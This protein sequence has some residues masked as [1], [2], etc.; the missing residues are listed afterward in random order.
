MRPLNVAVYYPWI[1]LHGGPERTIAELLARTGHRITVFT[2]RFE[3]DATFPS[4]RSAPIVELRRRVSV[5]RTF[6]DVGGAALRI[7]GEKLPLDG[8]DVL[9]VFCEG[10]GD[11][12]TLRNS[13]IPTVCLC[14]TPLRAAYDPEY[15]RGYLAMKG[16]TPGRRLLLAAAK[17]VFRVVDRRL[18]TRY[19]HVIAISAEVRKRI[20]AGGLFPKGGISIIHPGIDTGRLQPTWE[21]DPQFLIPGRIMWTKNL[22]LAIDAYRLLRER[23]PDLARF[24]LTLAGFVDEKSRPYLAALQRRAAGCDGIRFVCG[25]SDEE[26][27]SLCRRAWAVLYPP[28]NEDWGLVPLEAMALGKPIVASAR[29]GP[30][31][32]IV[33]GETGYLVPPAPGPFADAMER[34]ASDE[35]LVRRMGEAARQ[36][37]LSFDWQLF[38]DG[39]DAT[40]TNVAARAERPA[41]AFVAATNR[42]EGFAE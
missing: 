4:L 18:W 21:Y 35:G 39:F 8:F 14:F 15:Q 25:P 9:V 22:E 28:F 3:P 17:R 38:C 31:E 33:D 24:T 40:V 30:L 41:P 19:D 36:R 29:G 16:N 5:R 6:A 2:S 37:A 26:L 1:Y 12:V 10:L 32:T 42:S 7:A 11:F 27:F 13:R 34:L 20:E 23:R